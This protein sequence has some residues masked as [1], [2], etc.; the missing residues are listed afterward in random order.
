MCRSSNNFAGI[1]TES[2][3]LIDPISLTSTNTTRQHKSI[4]V[5][6]G[7]SYWKRGSGGVAM[8]PKGHD[9]R[10][11]DKAASRGS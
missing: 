11:F 7:L 9:P 4:F 6:V 8:S 2:K 5:Q 1:V 3:K 10:F